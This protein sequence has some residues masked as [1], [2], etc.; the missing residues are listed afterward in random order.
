MN[1]CEFCGE[2]IESGNECNSCK[3]Y[4][5]EQVEGYSSER[6]VMV[7]AN[8]NTIRQMYRPTPKRGPYKKKVSTA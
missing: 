7:E 2:E 8:K 3:T 1:E 5:V 4:R 6:N